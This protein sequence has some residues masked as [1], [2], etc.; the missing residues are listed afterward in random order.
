M[1]SAE[2]GFPDYPDQL[3]SLGPRIRVQ[4]G[5]EPYYSRELGRLPDLPE[6]LLPALIDTGAS[7]TC[8]DVT[9]AKALDLPV[10]DRQTLVGVHGPQETDFYRAQVHVP[11]LRAMFDRSVAGLPLRSE[12]LP[13]F[14]LLGR[15]FLKLFTMTYHGP[16]GSVTIVRE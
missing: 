6:Y 13:F 12:R 4:I 1:R 14:A 3:V 5:F 16:T 10:V 8:I 15:D 2:C 9:L 7:N 11:D